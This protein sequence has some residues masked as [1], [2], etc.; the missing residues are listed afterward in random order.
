MLPSLVNTS[1]LHKPA[2]ETPSTE[3]AL[4]LVPHYNNNLCCR[5]SNK[6]EP[7][8]H[9]PP[10]QL[11]QN[12]C[13]SILYLEYLPSQTMGM[14]M[15]AESLWQEHPGLLSESRGWGRGAHPQEQLTRKHAQLAPT[16]PPPFYTQ[17]LFNLGVVFLFF[18]FN[19]VYKDFYSWFQIPSVSSYRFWSVPNYGKESWDWYRVKEL[20]FSITVFK[21][22]MF[23]WILRTRF[24]QLFC[25]KKWESRTKR[26][27]LHWKPY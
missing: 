10:S 13:L 12:I 17:G 1:L 19:C 26:L 4:I 18:F 22:P 3:K 2:D 21:V 23:I 15:P 20:E 24:P 5:A 14:A 6:P 27:C 9:C 25:F 7:Q 8:L 16:H 11:T